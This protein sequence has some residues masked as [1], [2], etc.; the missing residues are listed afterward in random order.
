MNIFMC[1]NNT[2]FLLFISVKGAVEELHRVDW[3]W[4]GRR[5]FED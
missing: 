4:Q 5:F 1:S 2:P 3:R